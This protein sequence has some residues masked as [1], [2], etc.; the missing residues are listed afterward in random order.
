LTIEFWMN[1][2]GV[3]TDY[4]MPVARGDP[5]SPWTIFQMYADDNTGNY[6]EHSD[7]GNSGGQMGSLSNIDQ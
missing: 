2:D 1:L 4:G 5:N 6:P 3:D 7:W